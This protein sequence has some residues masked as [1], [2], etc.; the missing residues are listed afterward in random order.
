MAKLMNQGEARQRAQT[1][2]MEEG[3]VHVATTVRPNKEGDGWIIGGWADK[4]S[5]WVVV[6]VK[7]PGAIPDNIVEGLPNE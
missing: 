5:I 3:K 4:S 6:T 7:Y 1:L 2:S